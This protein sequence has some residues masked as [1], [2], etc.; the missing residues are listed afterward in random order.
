VYPP[1][2]FCFLLSQFQLLLFLLLSLAPGPACAQTPDFSLINTPWLEISTAHFNVYTCGDPPLAYKLTGHLEQFSKA[3]AVLAGTQALASPPIVV[4]AFPDHDRMKPFLPLYQGQPANLAGFFKRGDDENLIV[5]SLPADADGPPDMTVVFHEYTHLL[6]RH[7]DQ[8]WPLWLKEGMA[9][10]YSTFATT[11][12]GVSIA[13]PI[14]HHL[15]LLQQTPLM[16]LTDLFA[17]THD[18]PQ[19]NESSR[20]GIFYAESWLLTQFLMAG[21]QPALRARFGRY[22]YLLRAGENNVEAFTNAL[23]ISLPAMEAQLRRYLDNNLFPPLEI[24]LTAN[25]SAPIAISTH[26]LTPVEK[27]FR[28]GDELLRIDRLDAATTFF[29]KAQHD[30]PAGPLPYEGLGF[31]A[32]E[33]HQSAEALRN[34]T[35]ALQHGSTSFLAYYNY[36]RARYQ[37]TSHDAGGGD[38]TYAPLPDDAAAEVRDNL[39]K[40]LT[41]MPDFAPAQELLGYFEMVQGDNPAAAGTHLRR[42]IELEPESPAYIYTLAQYLYRNQDSAAALATLMPILKPN[43]DLVIRAHAQSLIQENTH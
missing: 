12:R 37:L 26:T 22:T 27:Y 11:G 13:G 24:N 23:Q 1:S 38:E 5:L 40:S 25:L 39:E 10:C 21:N 41:L 3:Y 17:V 35:T 8:Y 7:N 31:L 29:K 19:Y 28:L 32:L 34:L 6:F 42:A 18:S 15:E 4:L 2:N 43:I 30:A 20:Q 36:A 14:G 16:P 33:N 9:E